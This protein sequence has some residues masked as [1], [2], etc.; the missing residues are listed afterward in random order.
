MQEMAGPWFL[1]A[2]L[3]RAPESCQELI[4]NKSQG[5]T[6]IRSDSRGVR[7]A[8]QESSSDPEVAR[9]G[10]A[11]LDHLSRTRVRA[12]QSLKMQNCLGRGVHGYTAE[13]CLGRM[14]SAVVLEGRRRP[15]QPAAQ[16]GKETGPE[17]PTGIRL[18]SRCSLP[19][20][21]S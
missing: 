1:T 6:P 15:A 17:V 14:G 13:M 4:K 16:A 20:L 21:W 8:A 10:P 19:Q 5:L 18:F 9:A 12:T 11:T 2:S 7:R 3:D